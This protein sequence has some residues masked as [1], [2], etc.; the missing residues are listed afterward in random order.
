MPRFPCLT[1]PLS[2]GVI[3]VSYSTSPAE[4]DRHGPGGDFLQRS[5]YGDPQK[6]CVVGV[7][8]SQMLVWGNLVNEVALFW[9]SL[10]K[11]SS[12]SWSQNLSDCV[13]AETESAKMVQLFKLQSSEGEP[14]ES[15]EERKEIYHDCFLFGTIY[16]TIA[17]SNLKADPIPQRESQVNDL[18]SRAAGQP[19]FRMN[20][21]SQTS[22]RSLPLSP[23]PT[24]SPT[25]HQDLF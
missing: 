22:L 12:S 11:L 19:L 24:V 10:S 9:H 7:I 15:A 8:D 2:W 14:G 25:C 3:K 17:P 6:W 21:I 16:A 5:F 18:E 1:S 13:L 20:L 4:E 23:T